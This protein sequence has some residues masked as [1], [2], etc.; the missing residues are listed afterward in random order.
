MPE[1]LE[2]SFPLLLFHQHYFTIFVAANGHKRLLWRA[3]NQ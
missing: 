1:V 3:A 2:E